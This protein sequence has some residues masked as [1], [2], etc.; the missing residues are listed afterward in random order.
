MRKRK[1]VPVELVDLNAVDNTELATMVQLAISAGRQPTEDD[2]AHVRTFTDRQIN[3]CLY[4]YYELARPTRLESNW[5]DCLCHA[6][7]LTM[8]SEEM[9]EYHCPKRRWLH[10]TQAISS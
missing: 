7:L 4:R 3:Q 10:P 9:A 6:L 5:A 1:T 8:V 2:L